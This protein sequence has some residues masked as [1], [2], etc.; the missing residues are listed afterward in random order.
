[1]NQMIHMR[2]R[3]MLFNV[4]SMNVYDMH[5]KLHDMR[6]WITSFLVSNAYDIRIYCIHIYA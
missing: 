2:R 4:M 3:L 6:E 1:M 5:I